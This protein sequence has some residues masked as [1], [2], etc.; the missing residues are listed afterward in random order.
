MQIQFQIWMSESLM[1]CTVGWSLNFF[2]EN[3]RVY[4][5]QQLAQEIQKY[6]KL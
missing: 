4:Q 2:F 5:L 1:L 6:Y 3:D